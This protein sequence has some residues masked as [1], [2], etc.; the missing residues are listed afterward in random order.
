MGGG[1][2]GGGGGR[3]RER[4]ESG[5][6]GG[7]READRDFC[8]TDKHEKNASTIPRSVGHCHV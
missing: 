1:G 4:E 7:A 3:Q 8:T 5:G 2:G 6:G